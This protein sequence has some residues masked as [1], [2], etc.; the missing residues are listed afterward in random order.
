MAGNWSVTSH[1]ITDK[2]TSG[3]EAIPVKIAS[4]RP[5]N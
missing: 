1:M 3:N 2:W 5:L 4:G